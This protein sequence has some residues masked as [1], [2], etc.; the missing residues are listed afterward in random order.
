MVRRDRASRHCVRNSAEPE[1]GLGA[2]SLAGIIADEAANEARLGAAL[3]PRL[4]SSASE[5]RWAIDEF[6]GGLGRSG[7]YRPDGLET[8]LDCQPKGSGGVGI[9]HPS[10][11]Q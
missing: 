11:P 5:L 8:G 3:T 4:P 6:Q 1:P 9:P 10:C 7:P 2:S